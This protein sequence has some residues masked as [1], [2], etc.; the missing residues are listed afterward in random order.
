MESC[1]SE[2]GLLAF[3]VRNFSRLWAFGAQSGV[4]IVMSKEIPDR[5]E[6][7]EIMRPGQPPPMSAAE[8]Q[9]GAAPQVSP[10]AKFLARWLDELLNVPGTKFR[11]GLD[12]ILAMIPGV[13]DVVASGSGMVIILEAVRSGVAIPVLMRMGAN[14][15]INTA[16]DAIPLIGPVGSAFFKSNSRNLTLLKNWQ[17]GH[18]AEIKKS[19]LRF[20]VA[21]G[22]L[23]VVLFAIW[24][25][26]WL[27]S[28]WL[29]VTVAKYFNLL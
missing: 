8:G 2:L 19:T 28:I 23:L 3:F 13:G 6:I 21:S 1:D 17:T 16:L 18:Q 24:V 14:M 7:D 25:A 9:G 4:V 29:F 27:F 10:L 12:P 5:I 11:I 26:L 15:L 20:F 22:I